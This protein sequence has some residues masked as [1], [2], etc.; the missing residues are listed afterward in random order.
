MCSVR[1]ST[2]ATFPATYMRMSIEANG[3]VK[4]TYESR[5]KE[6][7]IPIKREREGI[8]A[9][10]AD[11]W[12]LTFAAIARL[13]L[14]YSYKTS[15]ILVQK[16]DEKN[17]VVDLSLK[18]APRLLRL[19]LALSAGMTEDGSSGWL[20]ALLYPPLAALIAH[21]KGDILYQRVNNDWDFTRSSLTQ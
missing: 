16:Y 8:M 20:T 11:V 6:W 18:V 21:H 10:C 15:S 13:I 1:V 3:L 7:Q 5:S 12:S 9:I 4:G 17:F 2:W 14:P 19:L